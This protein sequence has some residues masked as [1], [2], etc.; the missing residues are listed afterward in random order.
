MDVFHCVACMG[1]DWLPIMQSSVAGVPYMNEFAP[2]TVQV[3]LLRH[4]KFE[5]LQYSVMPYGPLMEMV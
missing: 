4:V 5:S 1:S 2:Y 3:T